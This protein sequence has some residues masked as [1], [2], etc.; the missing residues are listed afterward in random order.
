MLTLGAALRPPG[1]PLWWE[2][3]AQGGAPWGSCILS[4]RPD[5]LQPTPLPTVLPAADGSLRTDVRINIC[6]LH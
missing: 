1:A 5:L 4:R 2:S 3:H 6:G